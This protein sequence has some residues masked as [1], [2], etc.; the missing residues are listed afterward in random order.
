MPA[1]ETSSLATTNGPEAKR[2]AELD[3]LIARRYASDPLKKKEMMEAAATLNATLDAEDKL[4]E[5]NH[6]MM[7][8]PP[9]ENFKPEPVSRKISLKLVLENPRIP[10]G[11]RPRFRLELANVGTSTIEYHEYQPSVFVK[12]G[13]LLDSSRTIHFY[14]TDPSGRRKELA[15]RPP[16]ASF[17]A[18]RSREP[19]DVPAGLSEAGKKKW[20]IETNAASSASTSFKVRLAPGE[21]L[22]SV[23]DDDSSRANF[24]SLFSTADFTRPGSYKLEV[25]LDDRPEPL[26]QEEIQDAIGFSTPEETRRLYDRRLKNALGPVRSNVVD[27]E[28]VK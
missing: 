11:G 9:S 26:T 21:I 14:L 22:R 25:L 4:A 1:Q 12:D 24:K 7:V 2:D 28:V 15:S 10:E 17:Q 23:G 16:P 19:F 20:F 18:N 5:L 6:R 8:D 13:G 3:E 27:I